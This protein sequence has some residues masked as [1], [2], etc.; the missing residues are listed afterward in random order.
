MNSSRSLARSVSLTW[1]LSQTTIPKRSTQ[2][3]TTGMSQFAATKI[4]KVHWMNW[5]IVKMM[6]VIVEEEI[7]WR[8]DSGPAVRP[9]FLVIAAC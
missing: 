1:V 6:L 5:P 9:A 2:M 3:M 7:K 8:K 4:S